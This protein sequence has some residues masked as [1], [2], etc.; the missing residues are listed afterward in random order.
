M[1]FVPS[2]QC[3]IKNEKHIFLSQQLLEITS[4]MFD[5]VF[6]F[7]C[8]CV[9]TG[10]LAAGHF[11]EKFEASL[12]SLLSWRCLHLLRFKGRCD[13]AT[14][15][16]PELTS[17]QCFMSRFYLMF[18]PYYILLFEKIWKNIHQVQIVGISGL[19]EC[20]FSVRHPIF[21]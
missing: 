12:R 15:S 6:V 4:D 16:Q 2:H 17:C 19:F 13:S 1:C 11:Q 9:S 20:G 8:V 14:F 7:I 21:I 5:F 10:T 18:L 3:C